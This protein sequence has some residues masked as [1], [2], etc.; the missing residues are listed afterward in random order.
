[1]V[2]AA[3]GDLLSCAVEMAA[4][5]NNSVGLGSHP[6]VRPSVAMRPRSRHSGRLF[7]SSQRTWAPKSYNGRVLAVLRA[8]RRCP[9]FPTHWP[10]DL[11]IA[12][13]DLEAATLRRYTQ[14]R[15]Y[16]RVLREVGTPPSRKALAE[17]LRQTLEPVRNG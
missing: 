3:C 5:A 7:S 4:E 9:P 15:E 11:V 6:G 1:M 8:F 2:V 14:G 16:K 17:L 12:I 13:D 10:T